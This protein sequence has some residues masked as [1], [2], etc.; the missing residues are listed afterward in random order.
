M[1]PGGK[2]K[3]EMT[4][5]W[6]GGVWPFPRPFMV[7]TLGSEFLSYSLL[8]L[9]ETM[10]CLWQHKPTLEIENEEAPIRECDESPWSPVLMG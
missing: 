1:N 7:F 6:V 2:C 10:V 5:R 9:W 8:S 4:R 3:R